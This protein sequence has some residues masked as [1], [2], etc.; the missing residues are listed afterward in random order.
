MRDRQTREIDGRTYEVTQLDER[1]ARATFLRLGKLLGPSLAE[2]SKGLATGNL[3][4]LTIESVASAL[5]RLLYGASEE[6]LEYFCAVMRKTTKVQ[7][8]PGQGFAQLSEGM[9]RGQLFSLFKW[10]VFAF[11]VNYTDFLDGLRTLTPAPKSA[12]TNETP[13]PSASPAA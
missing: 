9:F 2:L 3:G 1:T 8:L 6:D 13:S 7:V 5:A 11:E 12:E 10:L 4:D